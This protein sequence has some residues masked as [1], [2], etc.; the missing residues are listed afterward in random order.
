MAF[1]YVNVLL[2]SIRPGPGMPSL[3]YYAWEL[4]RLLS[5]GSAM[6]GSS[7][8][9]LCVVFC[10]MGYWVLDCVFQCWMLAFMSLV[11]MVSVRIRSR[12]NLFC[13]VEFGLGLAYPYFIEGSGTAGKA[14]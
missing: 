8:G 13:I 12:S 5:F 1:G 4:G 9:G 10:Y 7:V 11:L 2:E 14:V 6:C 3:W